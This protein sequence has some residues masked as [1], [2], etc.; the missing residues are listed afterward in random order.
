LSGRN[1]AESKRDETDEE[2]ELIG[3]Q[4]PPSESSIDNEAPIAFEIE[5]R[6]GSDC[7]GI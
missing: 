5:S 2:D 4:L 3:P 7:K 1:E 6:Y